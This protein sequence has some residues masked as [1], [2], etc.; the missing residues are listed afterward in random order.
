VKNAAG[1]NMRPICHPIYM[2]GLKTTLASHSI[3]TDP[4]PP[5]TPVIHGWAAKRKADKHEY[6]SHRDFFV[7]RICAAAPFEGAQR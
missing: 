3:R 6:F 1:K 4:G 5:Y 2:N 7:N